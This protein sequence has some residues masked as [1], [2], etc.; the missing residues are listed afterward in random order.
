[1][2]PVPETDAGKEEDVKLLA[3]PTFLKKLA[4]TPAKSRDSSKMKLV[5][6]AAEL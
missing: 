3:E 6:S 2:R 4:S 1:L 5:P